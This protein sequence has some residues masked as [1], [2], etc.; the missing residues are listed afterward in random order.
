M[1]EWTEV[2]ITIDS[3]NVDKAGDIASMVVP[4]GIYIE[5][6][7]DLEQQ[8]WEVAHIDLIDE[9]LLKKDRSKAIVHVYIS[10]E[11]SPAEAVSFLSERYSAEGIRNQIDL[12]A[13]R[14][15][16]W[17]NNWKQYFHP[18]P[19]G[20]KLL[21]QP[22]WREQPESEGRKVLKIEPGLAF[23]TGS[24]DTTRL[25]L[26]TLE[27]YVGDGKTILDIGCGSGILSIASLL[28]GAEK[29]VGVDIDPLAVKTAAENGKLNGFSEPEFTVYEGNL[30]DKV[31][32]VYD[33]VVANIVADVIIL[34]CRDAGKFMDENSVFITSGIIDTREDDVLTA[35]REY[36]FE[37]C[38]RREKGGWLCFVVKKS[39][40]TENN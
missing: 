16:D 18:M 19:V 12:I 30:V 7:S 5:D 38:E 1:S 4:Y 35:F 33:I 25:C 32:G 8:A 14:N 28:L 39:S 10:P 31:S 20:E 36:G 21:I 27:K 24:H 40:C 9:E 37:V 6:Y 34:F 22:L 2:R 15:E 26:E 13:C 23:G 29:A 3:E 11:E 17:E